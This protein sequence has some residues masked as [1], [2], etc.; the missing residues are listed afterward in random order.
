MVYKSVR[1][2]WSDLPLGCDN[3]LTRLDK[4]HYDLTSLDSLDVT[5]L[6]LQGPRSDL[7][8]EGLSSK[9]SVQIWGPES[10][11][12]K[13]VRMNGLHVA[14]LPL[15]RSLFSFKWTVFVFLKPMI[16]FASECRF[17]ILLSDFFS[18][19]LRRAVTLGNFTSRVLC[20]ENLLS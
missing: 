5:L 9:R 14:S 8:V 15:E 3:H 11:P 12:W 2:F 1:Y 10:C 18:S 19:D 16:T 6:R 17:T 20:Y 13:N 4:F 7:Q